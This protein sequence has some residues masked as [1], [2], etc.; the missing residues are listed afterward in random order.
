[1]KKI[2]YLDLEDTIIDDWMLQYSC[3][4]VNT[5]K[6]R[7]WIKDIGVTE[8][9]LFS[10]AISNQDDVNFFNRVLKSWLES[11]LEIKI[12]TTNCFTT[13]ILEST[14]RKSGIVFENEHECMLM[15]GKD[16]GFQRFMEI[17]KESDNHEIWFLDDVIE[18]KTIIYDTMILN[19]KNVG[20]L[21]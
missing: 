8:A 21:I 4:A 11:I 12:D 2:L 20:E 5:D 3:N 19:F 1:M 6:V 16:Y 14:M 9:R 18:T 10:F 13:E 15:M 17:T 7:R